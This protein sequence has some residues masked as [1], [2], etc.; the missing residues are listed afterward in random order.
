MSREKVT[1][2]KPWEKNI[3]H[4]LGIITSGRL[5]ITSGVTA[6]DP[7]GDLVGPN[8]ME[9]QLNQIFSN[10]SDILA[11]AGGDFSKVVKYTIFVTD[12]E[13]CMASQGAY[14]KYVIDHPAST[15]VEISKLV[16][17][18]MVAEVEAI[19]ALD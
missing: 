12:I 9:A 17:P 7:N 11:A 8:D 13:A 10:L 5:L 15:L 18:E 14:R 16:I 19:V 4:G 1:T 6:R 3:S 2:G